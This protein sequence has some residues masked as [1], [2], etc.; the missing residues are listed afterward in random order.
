MM[1]QFKALWELTRFDHALMLALAVIIGEAVALSGALPNSALL[2]LS[3]LPALFIEI[4]AFALN[5]YLDIESDKLNK[6]LDRP[7]VR[8]E[9]KKETALAISALAYIIGIGASFFI[10]FQCFIIALAFA[11]LSILYNYKLKDL[12][13][14]GNLYIGASMGIP[15]IFGNY[16]VASTLLPL[17]LLFALIAF[18]GGTAREIVKSIQDLEG[19]IAARN[20]KTLP[21]LLGKNAS[22]Y[23]A[24]FFYVLFMFLSLSPFFMHLLRLGLLSGLFIALA[25]LLV[26]LL[27]SRLPLDLTPEFLKKA[28]TM[29]LAALFFGLMGFLLAI[30]GL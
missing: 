7:L 18:I 27:V 5:D 19:D 16:A 6:R 1:K 25:E 30:F 14:L 15:F 29:S 22:A 24:L 4:G 28:R 3:I 21:A 2:L 10:N 13:L 23:F 11:L 26:L 12:P 17:S 9:L 8:G 20:S